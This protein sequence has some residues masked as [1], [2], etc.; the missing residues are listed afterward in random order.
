MG[1]F[2][3]K[4]STALLA[5]ALAAFFGAPFITDYY[6]SLSPKITWLIVLVAMWLVLIAI[7][8]VAGKSLLTDERG[9]W[10][11][12]RLQLLSWT[13]FLIPTIWSMAALRFLA[14]PA[15][16]LA[17]GMDD[18]LWALLGISAASSVGSPILLERKSRGGTLDMRADDASG[19]PNC[20]WTR[21]TAES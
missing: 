13:G 1:K 11:L 18:N 3:I 7:E 4:G 12:S 10:S 19:K 15:D 20:R 2:Q 9:R 14:G 5:L 17:L 16:P 6:L 21:R 8:K